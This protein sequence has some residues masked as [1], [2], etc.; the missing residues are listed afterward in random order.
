MQHSQDLCKPCT[1]W[2]LTQTQLQPTK[3]SNTVPLSNDS[4]T[5][6]PTQPS[7]FKASVWCGCP[8]ASTLTWPPTTVLNTQESSGQTSQTLVP[9]GSLGSKFNCFRTASGP[10]Y[11]HYRPGLVLRFGGPIFL[12]PLQAGISWMSFSKPGHTSE[13]LCKNW[14]GGSRATDGSQIAPDPVRSLCWVLSTEQWVGLVH[15]VGAHSHCEPGITQGTKEVNR[16][17]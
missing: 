11:C 8:S 14:C 1:C 13:H 9:L 7:V 10:R 12:R 3:E 16:V 4:A 5:E 15:C 6:F 2:A 17:R